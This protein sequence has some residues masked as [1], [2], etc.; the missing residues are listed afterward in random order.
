[1]SD[2][3]CR[4]CGRELPASAPAACVCP[5]SGK[6][7]GDHVVARRLDPA[8]ARFPTD[9]E[10]N[11]FVRYRTLTHAYSLARGHGMPDE[12]FV[13]LVRELDTSV[14]AVAGTG[15]VETPFAERRELATALGLDPRV[16]LWVK[17]ETGNVSG[18][19]KG[20][21]LMGL[22]ILGETLAR[23]GLSPAGVATSAPL[24]IA[25]C[26]NAALAAAVVARAWRRPLD[27]FIPT[28]ASPIVVRALESHDARVHVCH[29]DPGAVGD[30]CYLAFREAVRAGAVPFCCQGSDN[31]L[32]VEGG[33]T[34]GWEL[35]GA[36]IAQ[37]ITIDS[38]FVQVGGGAL[39]AA[40]IDAFRDANAA[41]APV[42]LP[43]VYA[44]QTRGAS[45]LRR[46]WKGVAS[47]ALAAL[48]HD[49]G[50][51]DAP[52]AVVARELRAHADSAAVR[53]A[54][55]H[56]ARHRSSFMWPWET[57]PV[58]VAHG[59]L[60]DETYDWLAVVQGMIDGGGHPV[61]VSE[62]EL[63]EANALAH[64]H[65]GIDVCITGSA[66]LAGLIQLQRSGVSPGRTIGLV[67]SGLRR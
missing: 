50:M 30:P 66:G 65:T 41:G 44:V 60:D 25:S 11:P 53:D 13:R 12:D 46:A 28:D 35:V 21:H 58:S 64:A 59:I 54:L 49:A 55:D 62:E 37:G 57:P 8:F 24:A 9:A 6:D 26:G 15:F 14:A 56:A 33:E 7:G 51:V 36:S 5:Q 40:C 43:A 2:L 18:S 47:R 27:V 19:H 10:P 4:G 61:V 38:L 39:A 23:L 52:D 45:P 3:Y 63:L 17:D 29:R 16:A 67:C 42:A 1:M 20:R 32:T 22:A 48:G 31:G 34:L